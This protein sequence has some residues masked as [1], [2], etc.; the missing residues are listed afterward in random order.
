MASPLKAL[1]DTATLPF[2]IVGSAFSPVKSFISDHKFVSV[3]AGLWAGPKLIG[4][5]VQGVSAL[6]RANQAADLSNAI[7]EAPAKVDDFEFS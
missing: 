4:G 1:K 5:A 2:R 3:L 6:V 7:V